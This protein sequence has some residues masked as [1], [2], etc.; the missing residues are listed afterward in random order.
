M[1]PPQNSSNLLYSA[2]EATVNGDTKLTGLRELKQ[3]WVLLGRILASSARSPWLVATFFQLPFPEPPGLPTASKS[4]I[5]GT[6]VITF[7][8]PLANPGQ[9]FIL[10]PLTQAQLRGLFCQVRP[11][12]QALSTRTRISLGSTAQLPQHRPR[13]VVCGFV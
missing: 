9:P 2:W 1:V 3:V 8:P 10:R 12:S 4:P 7:R 5:T 6:V 11:R 13:F